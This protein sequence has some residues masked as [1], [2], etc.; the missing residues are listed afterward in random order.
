[1]TKI[2]VIGFAN[3]G[4]SREIKRTQGS[5]ELEWLYFCVFKF[6]RNA[7]EFTSFFAK[8][9]EI[10]EN[11]KISP[12]WLDAGF[13]FTKKDVIQSTPFSVFVTKIDSQNVTKNRSNVSEK[14]NFFPF[15]ASIL[16]PF[17]IY[18]IDRYYTK[19][20]SRNFCKKTQQLM[21]VTFRQ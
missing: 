7:K 4:N 1:M 2:I 21:R 3:Q 10:C 12:H 19:L 18:A 11:K 5:S 8:F 15:W 13:I 9:R 6:S 17:D 14:R 16:I 20:I